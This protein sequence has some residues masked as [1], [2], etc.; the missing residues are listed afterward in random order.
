MVIMTVLSTHTVNG[1]LASEAHNCYYDYTIN[2]N[3]LPTGPSGTLQSERRVHVSW[4]LSFLVADE[5]SRT[6]EHLN[7]GREGSTFDGLLWKLV[8]SE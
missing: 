7:S 1:I 2:L 5:S 4:R 6:P 8:S 3:L